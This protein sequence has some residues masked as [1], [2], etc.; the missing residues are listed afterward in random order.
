SSL[1]E[2]APEVRLNLDDHLSAISRGLVHEQDEV[3]VIGVHGGRI[4][5]VVV[6]PV[7]LV[8][9]ARRRRLQELVVAEDGEIAIRGA[10]GH[11]VAGGLSWRAI[12]RL[13]SGAGI[14]AAAEVLVAIPP[15]HTARGHPA[16]LTGLIREPK[17]E[18]ARE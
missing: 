1:L 7:A 16:D 8:G 12:P 11:V 6:V 5:K 14:H 13:P 10:V 4:I 2:V 3:R 9:P 15:G 18:S 17:A